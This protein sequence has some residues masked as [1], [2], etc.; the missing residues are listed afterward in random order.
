[1]ANQS[2]TVKRGY[3]WIFV[4]QAVAKV[5]EAIDR[6]KAANYLGEVADCLL[7]QILLGIALESAV[8]EAG[9]LLLSSTAWAAL[10][11]TETHAKWYLMSSL[12]GRSPFDY[13]HEPMQ[14]VREVARKRNEFVHPKGFKHQNEIVLQD[15][16]GTV[17]RNVNPDQ[18]VQ[19]G[20][21]LITAA[22]ALHEQKELNISKTLDLLDRTVEAIIK[23]REHLNLPIFGF[24]DRARVQVE[25][26]KQLANPPPEQPNS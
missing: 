25:V 21:T 14:T 15:E 10:E 1:M 8:N 16:D 7:A 2:N 13:S 12:G 18:L 17:H 19:P 22:L 6:S 20:Q 23:L 4:A 26:L 24:M 3:T 9:D 5:E 11:K